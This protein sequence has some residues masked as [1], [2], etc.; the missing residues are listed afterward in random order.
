MFA[1][2]G[3]NAQDTSSEALESFTTLASLMIKVLT[4]LAFLF[5]SWGEKLMTS[6][7]ILAEETMDAIRSMWVIVRNITN[8][9][10]VIMLLFLAFSNLFSGIAGGGN[11]TIK[12]KL[13][14]IILALIAVNFSLLGFRVL[15][16]AT[17]VATEAILSIAGST[18]ESKG[19]LHQ[20]K[21]VMESPFNDKGEKCTLPKA[22]SSPDCKRFYEWVNHTMC[23]GVNDSKKADFYEECF[24]YVNQEFW[25]EQGDHLDPNEYSAI[26]LFMTFGSFFQHFER[27][28]ALAANTDSW[29]EVVDNVLFS[30]IMGLAFIVAMVALF[31]VLLL[32]VVVLWIMMVFSPF[33]VVGMIMGVGDSSKASGQVITYLLVPIK[34]AAI[35]VVTMILLMVQ[36]DMVSLA[37]EGPIQM[38]QLGPSLN[39]FGA[40]PASI[41]WQIATVIIFWKLAFW[42]LEGTAA[43]KI[44]DQIR[45][46][47]ETVGGYWAKSWTVDRPMIPIPGG[48]PVGLA[49]LSKLPSV[50]QSSREAE[51]G[52]QRAELRKMFGNVDPGV[53][54]KQTDALNDLN[55][56]INGHSSIDRRG[57]V[58]NINKHGA[59][60][61][62]NNR[63]YAGKYFDTMAKKHGPLKNKSLEEKAKAREQFIKIAEKESLK[64]QAAIWKSVFNI[65]SSQLKFSV[66]DATPTADV[67][68]QGGLQ[69]AGHK[70]F[71]TV[72]EHTLPFEAGEFDKFKHALDDIR[73][74]HDAN[75]Q[76]TPEQ[77]KELE[78]QV[79]NKG[80]FNAADLKKYTQKPTTPPS[81]P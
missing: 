68:K 21:K 43:Q 36:I 72:G 65:D 34:F 71:A 63:Q 58:E 66:S 45:G 6:D 79:F 10:F 73:E 20:L 54:K 77:M 40:G 28:P 57:I 44:V 5:M 78:E 29:T 75:F 23:K 17:Q 1:S 3:L 74:K 25:N 46:A 59:D 80:G 9:G 37:G 8:I 67:S 2:G 19:E 30:L 53:Q 38:I 41:L 7:L 76:I 35:L 4:F 32:R 13:P 39:Q 61:F 70:A 55:R 12:E 18:M 33:L 48:S 26:T 24:F 15:V 14:K 52:T 81:G 69:V 31:V 51:L 11:W 49:A 56:N 42:A 16:D 22:G 50:M 27:L 47:A 62:Q 64:E 60:V